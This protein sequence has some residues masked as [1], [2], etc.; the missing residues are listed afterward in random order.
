MIKKQKPDLVLV[1][2]DTNSTLAGALAAVKLHVPVAH[3][4]AGLRSFNR[5][6]PEEI[7]RGLTDHI[8]DHLYCPTQ[9]AVEHIRHEGIYRGVH[10]VGYV[11]YDSVLCN[12][13]LAEKSSNILEKLKL[14]YKSY[15]LATVHRVENTDDINRLKPIFFA[16][17]GYLKMDFQ[18]S[19][20]CALAPEN[21]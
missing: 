12:I 4:E 13:K 5:R 16:L 15:T 11:M 14:K 17:N 19:S 10:L 8:S 3:I 1:Y 9:T 18:L 2:G 6:M 20:L 7:N 21:L